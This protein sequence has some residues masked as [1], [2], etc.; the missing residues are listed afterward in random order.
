MGNNVSLD[1]FLIFRIYIIAVECLRIIMCMITRI[2][3]CLTADNGSEFANHK[4][5]ATALDAEF[6]FAH[7]CG[8][9][10]RGSNENTNGLLCQ[11]VPKGKNIREVGDDVILFAIARIN[12]RPEKCLGFKQLAVIFKEICMAA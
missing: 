6:N 5:I 12:Y 7:L 3:F 11:Y 8:S 4:E 2:G 1:R 10:E 9:L